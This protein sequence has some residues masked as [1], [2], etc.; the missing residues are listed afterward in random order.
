MIRASYTVFCEDIR[1]RGIGLN[2]LGIC[3]F[4]LDLAFHRGTFRG[5]LGY[6]ARANGEDNCVIVTRA[7]PSQRHYLQIGC[8]RGQFL[9]RGN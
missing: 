8:D 2:E 1:I 3:S 7:L 4:V 5:V 6:L 9:R